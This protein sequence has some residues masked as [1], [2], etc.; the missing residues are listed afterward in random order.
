VIVVLDRDRAFEQRHVLSSVRR[1]YYS[2][3]GVDRWTG[4]G[5]IL[6]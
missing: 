2:N 5:R 3:R 6:I 1:V 4:G